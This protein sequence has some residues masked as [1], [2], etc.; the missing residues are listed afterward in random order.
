MF[1]ALKNKLVD[2]DN[3]PGIKKASYWKLPPKDFCYGKKE[4][5]DKE[6]VSLGIK[7][8]I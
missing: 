1:Q 5:P 3:T 6:G 2:N 8:L 7:I 4:Q